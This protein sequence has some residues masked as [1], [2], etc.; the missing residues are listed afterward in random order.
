MATEV[1]GIKFLGCSVANF[2]SSMGFNSNP[3]T[4]SVTLVEDFANG[5]NF[6]ADNHTEADELAA[7]YGGS[8]FINGNPG[9][10]AKFSTPNNSFTFSGFVTSYRRSKS[11]SGNLINV[12][13]SDPRFLLSQIPIVNDTNLSINTTGFD[14]N[15]WN[16][17]C[18]PAVFPNPIEL[19]WNNQ[20]VRFD[21]LMTALAEKT[22]NFYGRNFKILLDISFYSL[23]IGGYRLKQQISSV[24]DAINQA[25]REAG[26]DWYIVAEDTTLGYTAIYVRGIK[27]KNQYAFADGNQLK[28]FISSRDGRVSS[29][30][31]G[32]ELRQEPTVTV[33]TG[34][35]VR[36]LWNTSPNGTYNIFGELG[37]GMV[38]DRP[39]VSLDFAKTLGWLNFPT[40][41]INVTQSDTINAVGTA[42]D[43]FSNTRIEYPTRRKKQVSFSRFGYVVTE[44]ILRAALYSKEAWITAVWYEYRDAATGTLRPI[45]YNIYNTFDL[46]YGFNA[47]AAQV[48]ASFTM[49]PDK[50]AIESPSYDFEK[51][52]P[53][54][55]Q[56][57]NYSD[58]LK[59]TVKEA[60]YQATLRCAQEYYGKKFICRLPESAICSEIGD[61][62]ANNEKKI[63]IEYQL[64]DA[65]PNIDYYNSI[66]EIPLPSSLLKADSESFRNPNGLFK[67]FCYINTQGV[68]SIYNYVRYDQFNPSNS[69]WAATT[70]AESTGPGSTLYFSGV[71]VE[72]YRFDPRFAIVTLNEPLNCGAGS[73]RKLTPT[74]RGS[75][76]RILN[77]T[78]QT[79]YVPVTKTDKTGCF[80]EFMSRVFASLS[81]VRYDDSR[82]PIVG[83]SRALVSFA[84]GVISADYYY[85]LQTDAYTLQ[86]QVGLAEYRLSNFDAVAGCG[87]FI[88][89]QWNYV[90]YG[91]WVN[92]T[93]YS[94]PVNII[95]DSKLNPWNYGSF[96]RM[97]AAGNIIAE[98]ANTLTHTIS[99]ATVVV[100][101]YPEYNLGYEI[102]SGA[103]NMG[104]ITDIN[105][106]FGPDGVRTTYKF[107]TFLGPGGFTKRGEL[108][109]IS[110][111]SFVNSNNRESSIQWQK[112]YEDI[113][114]QFLKSKQIGQS[115]FVSGTN[116]MNGNNS[117][118][119]SALDSFSSTINAVGKAPEISQVSSK[120]VKFSNEANTNNYSEAV[121]AKINTIF[122]PV[123]T[124]PPL[125]ADNRVP[126]I[127]GG[128]IA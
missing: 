34:D 73:Y 95:D 119:N 102:S 101:G 77:W 51:R 38:I 72:P 76:N 112:I 62:Y 56:V 30:E 85:G 36:T 91:P 48:Q 84:N 11:I 25:A 75:D 88:P 104:N 97:N 15:T 111:N 126:T 127:E 61:E 86:D 6:A 1:T 12:E 93:V 29:W 66:K 4:L 68:Q 19:D 54:Q 89:L 108:D 32:R 94:R 69:I 26:I 46:N 128:L 87:F 27:R 70:N 5:D 100:E 79:S 53:H 123:T 92:G 116:I 81:I 124:Q 49:D 114:G 67:A 24:D 55:S 82:L 122:T 42:R 17:F 60:A 113:E 9:T 13:L 14:I 28:T 110:Y 16:I 23:L 96:D 22:F 121:V 40:V 98:R 80:L 3:S 99:Y 58:V 120:A 8:F 57:N 20:G 103:D 18:A 33:V 31:I 59:E 10:F 74:V 71:S 65:A 45:T 41:S 37:N 125:N 90:K 63:P 118:N 35:R 50:L 21:K 52:N 7:T 107:K 43:D 83:G 78:T 115:S 2:S 44:T 117:T 105:L 109:T 47:P 39:F 64:A 106:G